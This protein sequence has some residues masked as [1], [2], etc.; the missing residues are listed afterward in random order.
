M[1]SKLRQL[2]S[3][4]LAKICFGLI[5][6]IFLMTSVTELIRP[7]GDFNIVSFRKLNNIK[8]IDLKRSEAYMLSQLD[9]TLAKGEVI[10]D[11]TKEQ[12][13]AYALSI[14]IK[15]RMYEAWTNDFEISINDK[16][17]ADFLKTWSIFHD[18]N[19]K[20]DINIYKN[21]IAQLPF[22]KQ[23]FYKDVKTDIAKNLLEGL[24]GSTIRLPALYQNIIAEQEATYKNADIIHIK[25]GAQNNAPIPGVN[26][27]ELESFYQN[28]SSQFKTPETRAVTFILIPYSKF[29]SSQ[30]DEGLKM[31]EVTK[32]LRAIEDLVAGGASII[33][34]AKKYSLETRN[35]AGSKDR[36]AKNPNLSKSVEQIFSMDLKEVSYPQEMQESKS[37][38]LFEVASVEQS[39]TPDLV[40][41]KKEV[42]RAYSINYYK[43][44]NKN[45]FIE[46]AQKAKNQNLAKLAKESGYEVKNITVPC[47]EIANE[48][49][50]YIEQLISKSHIQEVSEP[51]FLGDDDAYIYKI[52]NTHLDK[53]LLHKI[54]PKAISAATD[55]LKNLFTE[56]IIKYYYSMNE[57]TINYQ[58][59]K[60][61]F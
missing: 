1:F 19:K 37:I 41:I 32:E 50:S 23:S 49:K 40:D 13:Q 45:L 31:K 25:L 48:N 12:V 54:Q 44:I 9:G 28:H 20:F 34:I 42:L 52:N 10:D 3:T 27:T 56:E 8:L 60:V 15:K 43:E 5:A 38:L 59:L 16:L 57:P 17:T 4:L 33:E 47:R 58:M 7:T 55:D 30:T 46:F 18:E 53:A 21:F 11:Q 22:S 51:I 39:K 26:D 61:D 29:L 24:V 6:L 35:L 2:Q 36:F 14:L